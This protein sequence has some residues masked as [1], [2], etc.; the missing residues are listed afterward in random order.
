MKIKI[1]ILSFIILASLL[2][3]SCGI[4]PQSTNS[5]SST[6]TGTQANTDDIQKKPYTKVENAIQPIVSYKTVKKDFYEK[7]LAYYG[8]YEYVGEDLPSD[9]GEYY[10]VVKTYKDFVPL[11]KASYIDESVFEDNYILIIHR[12]YGGRYKT[13][14]GFS[15]FKLE[16]GEASIDL[17]EYTGNLMYPDCEFNQ[18][19]YYLIPNTLECE[20]AD[21]AQITIN[22]TTLNS[23]YFEDTEI[24]GL[25]LGEHAL[26]FDGLNELKAFAEQYAIDMSFNFFNGDNAYIIVIEA[27]FADIASVGNL[28]L[29]N[30]KLTLTIDDSGLYDW[31]QKSY[32]VI[33]V[34]RDYNTAGNPDFPIFENEISNEVSL[35]I[36]INENNQPNNEEITNAQKNRHTMVKNAVYPKLTVTT[37][38]REFYPQLTYGFGKYLG[39]DGTFDGY[40]NNYKIIKTYDEFVGLFENGSYIN[41]DVFDTSYVLVIKRHY[42]GRSATDVGFHDF[43]MENGEA[44]ISLYEYTGNKLYDMGEFASTEFILIPNTIECEAGDFKPIT[45]NKTTIYSYQVEDADIDGL[46]LNGKA[47]VFNNASDYNKFAEAY[48]ITKRSDISSKILVIPRPCDYI[49]SCGYLTLEGSKLTLKVD[50]GRAEHQ[51]YDKD[52]LIIQI[53]EDSYYFE[54][55]D[56]EGNPVMSQ[57]ASFKITSD[58]E[59]CVVIH[60][61]NRPLTPYMLSEEEFIAVLRS[62]GSN[63]TTRTDKVIVLENGEIKYGS[64]ISKENNDIYY[65]QRTTNSIGENGVISTHSWAYLLNWQ[66]VGAEYA[67]EIENGVWIKKD[68]L[69]TCY[70]SIYDHFNVPN[71]QSH[72][73]ELTYDEQSGMYYADVIVDYD[74]IYDVRLKIENGYVSYVSFRT[75]CTYEGADKEYVVITTYDVGSTQIPEVVV[76][77]EASL[78]AIETSEEILVELERRL[79]K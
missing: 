68:G 13:D 77:S 45:V 19:E 43:K 20:A 38:K 44:Q 55:V 12:K 23:Y 79:D 48:G 4:I 32:L 78:E 16:N 42:A 8:Q 41:E 25:E 69:W 27:P 36:I 57:H 51:V 33:S 58:M 9:F 50:K 18:T 7:I 52:Y 63:Q 10:K 6:N 26:I 62:N 35:E 74:T 64:K 1:A 59:L 15:S 39:N 56:S 21:F 76:D 60:D 40:G 34:P 67:C 49:E 46:E 37:E 30:G 3:A 11:V 70:S 28:T 71:L 61:D 72:Y 5:Q 75:D 22:K 14:M 29:E 31:Y 65:T 17:Y 54:D 53:Y 73:D 47:L 66:K 2:I 24:E